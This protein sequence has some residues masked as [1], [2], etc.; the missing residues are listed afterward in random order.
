MTRHHYTSTRLCANNNSTTKPT[1]KSYHATVTIEYCNVH[2]CRNIT[3]KCS[4]IQ[5]LKDNHYYKIRIQDQSP[6]HKCM[7][8]ES[9][10]T[11]YIVKL[12]F[13]MPPLVPLQQAAVTKLLL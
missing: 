8:E 11:T 3:A 13:T 9:Y 10:V 7:I 4:A 1:A 12:P 2:Y 5:L 6:T